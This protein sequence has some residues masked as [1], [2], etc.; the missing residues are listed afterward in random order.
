[1]ENYSVY[2]HI[3]LKNGKK[4]IGKAKDAPTKRWGINGKRYL[5]KRDGK[6]CQPYF[7]RAILKY[8]WNNFYHEI[9]ISGLDNQEACRQE[10]FFI[11]LF[12]SNNP[13]Y[14]YNST[15]RGEGSSG[16]IITEETRKKMSESQKERFQR[17]EEKE[18]LKLRSKDKKPIP[19]RR[20]RWKHTEEEKKHLSEVLKGRKLSEETK[21]KM[22]DG[23]QRENAHMYGK[24]HTEESKRKMSESRKGKK[25]GKDNPNS[26]PVICVETGE[27]FESCSLASIA[28]TGKP[29]Q[30]PHIGSVCHGKRKQCLN[31]HWKF[32]DD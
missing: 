5:V 6:F 9:L 18:K 10:K 31:F 26:K 4:Y 3:N 27:I 12:R 25:T 15:L 19:K 23:R 22:K 11:L 21:Q 16:R 28:L 7:A 17:P 24:K 30:G 32:V 1:M 29:I 14:G 8:G 20:E 13:V 2:L